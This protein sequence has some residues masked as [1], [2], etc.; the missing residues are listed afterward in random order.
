MRPAL[1]SGDFGDPRIPGVLGQQT[2]PCEPLPDVGI[3]LVDRIGGIG[4]VAEDRGNLHLPLI[5]LIIVG[6]IP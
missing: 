6:R 2:L 5:A 1:V 4:L 3:D